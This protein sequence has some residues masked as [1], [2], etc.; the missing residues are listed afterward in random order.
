MGHK[1]VLL[2]SVT[3]GF[4]GVLVCCCTSWAQQ[5]SPPEPV[6]NAKEVTLEPN[7]P[8]AVW[9]TCPEGTKLISGGGGSEVFSAS[10]FSVVWSVPLTG[11]SEG[12][13]WSVGIVNRSDTPRKGVIFAYAMCSKV[14]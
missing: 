7:S 9:V 2:P 8:E 1:Q 5:M 11:Q 4:L 14:K 13:G 3:A 10:Y 12:D 6:Q